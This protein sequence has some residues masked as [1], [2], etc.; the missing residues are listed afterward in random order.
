MA[1]YRGARE[2][3][4]EFLCDDGRR[5]SILVEAIEDQKTREAKPN[6]SDW[7]KNDCRTSVDAIEAFHNSYNKLGLAKITCKPILGS[8][9]N[10]EIEGVA[11]SV[12]L[13][14]TTHRV[15]KDKLSRVGGLIL[16]LAKSEPSARNRQE[17]SKTAAVLVALFAAKHLKHAGEADPAICLSLDVFGGNLI[18][19][20]NSYIKRVDNMS[21]SC[22][23]IALRWPGIE[24]PPDYDGPDPK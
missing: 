23:E 17:R 5:V 9:P 8:L 15:D 12:N 19:A 11:V 1:Q 10:L 13:D 18:K 7:V 4:P 2:S 24:P 16:S 3:I 22:E 21:A 14:A 20:P 6:A